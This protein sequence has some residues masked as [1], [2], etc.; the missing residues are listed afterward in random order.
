ML[1]NNAEFVKV[2]E[3]NPPPLPNNTHLLLDGAWN[4]VLVTDNVFG[5]I[6]VSP[7]AYS[8]RI[9]HD[10][11]SVSP[12]VV[13]STRDRNILAIESEVRGALGNGVDSFLIVVG[14]TIPHVEHLAGR[15]E[16]VKH[17]RTLQESLPD[18]EVGSPTSFSAKTKR[19]HIDDGAQFLVAGP[20]LDPATVEY[21]IDKLDL[22]PDDPPVFVMVIPPFSTRWID[23]MQGIGARSV[24][25]DLRHSLDA[26]RDPAGRREIAWEASRQAATAA[27]GAGAA[28]AIL[29]GLRFDTIIDEAALAWSDLSST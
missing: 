9:T 14:D 28:G 11:P 4:H 6:R 19:R 21:H 3:V 10:A 7:Y 8:A 13:V 5:R 16:I 12:T 23:R 1:S 2:A 25:D 29:M 26:A 18:F 17:L 27:E 22:Q 20:L 24:T 15:L